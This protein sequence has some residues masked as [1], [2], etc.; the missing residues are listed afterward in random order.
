VSET[1]IAIIL[2]LVEGITEY[3]PVSSTGHLILF[4]DILEFNGE[5]A[6]TF[7][8]VI[9]L[10]AI[11][12]VLWLY[13]P[14]FTALVKG[15]GGTFKEPAQVLDPGMSGA[16]GLFKLGLV[17]GPALVIGALFGSKIKA[18]LFNSTSVAIALAVGAILILLVEHFAKFKGERDANS[19]TWKKSILIGCVQCLA[20][21]PGMSRSASA[22]IGGMMVGL[23]RKAAAEFSF[24]AAVPI[25]AA[26][27]IHDLFKAAAVFTAD[28]I[29]L[30]AIGF[31]VSFITALLTVKWFIG[32]VSRWSLRPF[33]YYRLL[34]AAVVLYLL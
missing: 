18:H 4:G 2:G 19:L 8:V 27:A 11:L 13:W 17:T 6:K 24:L 21:W 28:D 15:L 5:K 26:A 33:A 14:R 7:D 22:I 29:K 1:L 25:L 16:A 12:S 3:L 34:V 10:G 9:Q 31:S 32:V 20:L 23:S 30:V